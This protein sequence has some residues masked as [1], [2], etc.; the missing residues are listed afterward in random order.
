METLL[1]SPMF[2][3]LLSLLAFECACIIQKKTKLLIF[4]PL[5]IAIIMVIIFLAVTNI[6]ISYYQVGGNIINMFLGPATVV[7][8]VPL[9]RNIKHLKAYVIPILLGIFIGSLVGLI[10]TL[11]CSMIFGFD[12]QMIASLLPKSVTT[13]IGV[14]L[15]SQLGG[16]PSITI[17]NI[18]VTG[19]I[20]AVGADITCKVFHITE[21]VAKGIA[22]GTSSHALGT[23]KAFQM[24]QVEG[25]MSSLAIGIAGI[26]TV[27]LAPILW[28]IIIPFLA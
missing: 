8:A 4:N 1:L 15:S 3:I 21:P 9:Y 10:S 26:M 25:A 5:M 11:A 24:G 2:G 18:L 6:D 22:I 17:F 12:L 19:I 28:N 20:G 16:I 13:P 14:E 23:T 7:L 27:I